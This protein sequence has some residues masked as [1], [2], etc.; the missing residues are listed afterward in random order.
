[1]ND[2]ELTL[3]IK[4]NAS[5]LKTVLESAKKT[6][7]DAASSVNRSNS[8]MKNTLSQLGGAFST[9]SDKISQYA[10]AAAAVVVG[11]SFGAKYFI[12]LASSLQTTQNRMASLVGST[13]L[14]NKMFGELY[15]YTLGKPIAFPDASRAMQTIVGYGVAAGDAVDAM[16]AISKFAIING[17]DLDLLALAYGQVNAKGKL[18]GQEILQLTNN[19]VPVRQMLIKFY[20]SAAIAQQKLDDGT[21]SAADFNKAMAN[22]IPDSAIAAQTNTFKNRMIS[23]QGT[24][25]TVG[26]AIL[27]LKVDQQNG[28]VIDQSGLFMKMTKVVEDFT[29]WLKDNKQAIVAIANVVVDN[30]VP[31]LTA[32]ATAFV[33]LK[34]AAAIDK[35]ITASPFMIVATAIGIVV[36]ALT[37]LQ[38]KFNI[39]G[40]AWEWIKKTWGE[41]VKW[42]QD[43]WDGITAVFNDVKEW[44]GKR[45]DD[46]K[47]AVVAAWDGVVKKFT[48]VRDTINRFIEEHKQAIINW[49]IVITTFLLPKIVSIGVQWAIAMAKV[50][51]GGAVAAAKAVAHAAV[52]AAEWVVGAAKASWAW[53]VNMPKVIA[54]FTVASAQ[55]VVKAAIATAA[56]VVSAAQTAAAWAVTFAQFLAGMAVMVGQ[57]LLQAARMA[58]GWLL[59][60]GPIGLIVAIVAGIVALIIA[61][62]DTVRQAF[63]NV[64]I[65]IQQVWQGAGAWFGGIWEGIKAAFGAVGS[66]FKD[67]FT[68]AWKAVQ[69]VF[70]AGG[71]IFEGIKDG[72]TSVFKTV[73]NGIIDG[74]NTVIKIPFDGINAA[75]SG[76]K[77]VNIA[78][79]KPFDW[80]PTISVPQI[81]RLATGGIVDAL[82]GGA[83]VTV[84]E[85]GV[86]EWIVPETKMASLVNQINQRLDGSKGGR[87]V[88]IN[89]NFHLS[90]TFDAKRAAS[91]MGYLASR[92]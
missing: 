44:F 49:S 34:A 10:K 91:E 7:E 2:Q 52:A 4:A 55:A 63:E 70:S 40:Q 21:V 58:A 22:F 72:I 57:F 51:A 66:W 38:I 39:F 11:S 50:I 90:N 80:I 13:E 77:G 67:T 56:W 17:A 31:G 8:G 78:G 18:M 64:W 43:V 1:M 74:I 14:A 32:L 89:Q 85:G 16:K 75:L 71:K 92:I 26:L 69:D 23:L 65:S 25:R 28:L 41:S 79:A 45:F 30:L 82:R 87:N 27:G 35:I 46:A 15:N 3:T 47:N 59:A 76:I 6:V 53:I 20:G 73:V 24:I 5:Q 9:V 29:K 60:M 36:A 42:F 12:D 81:P 54:Q 88:T 83:N 37:Y 33:V 61:N 68:A 19:F 84:A 86:N 62:W 48:D